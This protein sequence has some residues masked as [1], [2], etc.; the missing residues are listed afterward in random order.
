[1]RFLDVLAVHLFLSS[2]VNGMKRD[3]V[4]PISLLRQYLLKQMIGSGE[5]SA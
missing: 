3:D 2:R 1:M 4:I 5:G